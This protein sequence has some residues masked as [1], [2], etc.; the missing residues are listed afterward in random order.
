MTFLLWGNR[1]YHY[2]IVSAKKY[3]KIVH[4][5]KMKYFW[6]FCFTS[7]VTTWTFRSWRNSM[8]VLKVDPGFCQSRLQLL[9]REEV[10]WIKRREHVCLLQRERS[11]SAWRR[12]YRLDGGK[13]SCFSTFRLTHT[14]FLETNKY[15][16]QRTLAPWGREI[17]INNL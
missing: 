2:T 7:T 13:L 17:I 8:N 12:C 6:L 10:L 3:L 9:Q 4:S 5:T 14:V 1:D 15:I 11:S 16:Q